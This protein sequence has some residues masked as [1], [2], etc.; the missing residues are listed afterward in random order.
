MKIS[1]TKGLKSGGINPS[2]VKQSMGFGFVEFN[3]GFA[4]KKALKSQQGAILDGHS[5]ELSISKSGAGALAERYQRASIS[6]N[7]K[8]ICAIESFLYEF[9]DEIK[10]FFTNSMNIS[11]GQL[12]H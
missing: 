8:L 1:A 9:F 3:S 5:L 7:T 4:A 12:A 11:A 6:T 2:I 10:T